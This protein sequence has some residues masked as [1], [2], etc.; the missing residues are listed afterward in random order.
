MIGDDNNDDTHINHHQ[1]ESL[2]TKLRQVILQHAS[3]Q[4]PEQPP[5]DT[6]ATTASA[7]TASDDE[8]N[9]ND[10]ISVLDGIKVIA[11]ESGLWISGGGMHVADAPPHPQSSQQ[12]RRV[13]NTH[14]ILDD[15]G[16]VQCFYRKIHLFDVSIPGKVDLRE[17]NTTAGGNELV[18]CDSPIGTC[19]CMYVCACGSSEPWLVL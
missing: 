12:Q 19:L 3:N 6:T 7:A 11:Q 5:S 13:Y 17:S 10:N 15:H 18:V 16:Q 4:E 14:V 2:R 1:V 9:N 8:E